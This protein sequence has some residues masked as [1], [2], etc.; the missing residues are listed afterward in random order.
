M[1]FFGCPIF[2]KWFINASIELVFG[3][4]TDIRMGRTATFLDLVLS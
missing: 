2:S 4:N 1:Y 3:S